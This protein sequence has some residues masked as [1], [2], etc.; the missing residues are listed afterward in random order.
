MS[1][2]IPESLVG[3]N[4]EMAKGGAWMVAMRLSIRGIGIL[5]TI[6][7]ARLL[8]PEDFGLVAMAS[9][10]YGLIEILGQFGF[11][12][13]LIQKRDAEREHY[14]TVWTLS[15]L[16]GLVIAGILFGLAGVAAEFFE[17]PLLREIIYAHCVIAIAA[18]FVN[19]G[20]VDFRKKM[21]FER[22]FKFSVV[23]KLF[24]FVVTISC[25]L[26][27]RNYWALVIGVASGIA[28]QLVLSYTM[29]PYRPRLSLARWH[30]IMSFSKWVLVNSL[31]N[32]VVSRAGTFFV[33]KLSGA[34]AVG[35]Y[36][37][38]FEVS[39]LP[40]SELLAPI[41]RAIFPG[42]V[43]LAADPSSLRESFVRIWAIL[44]M[45]GAPMAMGIFL[46]ADPLVRVA[47]GPNWLDAIPLMEVLAIYGLLATFSTVSG[48]VYMALG[49]L[50]ILTIISVI[51]ALVM[52][53]SLY[54]GTQYA[55]AYGAALALTLAGGV[56]VAIDFV[57]I[58]RLVGIPAVSVLAAGWRT[59]ASTIVMTVAV[60][61]VQ[62]L[63]S[64]PGTTFFSHLIDLL[65]S[66]GTGMLAY[67]ATHL[68]TWHLSGR[69]D[70]PE[71]DAY[72][73]AMPLLSRRS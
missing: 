7:L 25:A 35:L 73:Y 34:Q 69:P 61:G 50:R 40:T 12:L 64:A 52:I 38:A 18:G 62:S 3:V 67:L 41:R 26:A 57:V 53:P 27:L 33:S 72:A 2:P 6:I 55:G 21:I 56:W 65:L 47:L 36:T 66:V 14:D 17:D 48:P 71:S 5:S 19:V 32:Y 46:V 49:R 28:A 15:I 43:M 58:T 37:V 11:D 8:L 45:L 42:F 54:Y 4:R 13:A 44:L 68:L 9:L 10:I 23:T 59:F 60:L 31:L 39:N 1:E 51:S 16:R 30:E 22:E 70:G 63:I 20:I 24:S 29:H